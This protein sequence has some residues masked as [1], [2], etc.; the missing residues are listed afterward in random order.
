MSTSAARARRG[1]SLRAK[2]G[3][4]GSPPSSGLPSGASGKEFAQGLGD[5]ALDRPI[6]LDAEDP[7]AQRE[8]PRDAGRQPDDRSGGAA[9][10]RAA[11]R[12]CHG[13]FSYFSYCQGSPPGNGEVR[14]AW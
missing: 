9:G 14:V 7:H 6:L 5:E 13:R 3:P 1:P 4:D 11:R 12:P 2:R 8:P 10:L